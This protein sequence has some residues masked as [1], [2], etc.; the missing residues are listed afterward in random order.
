MLVTETEPTTNAA[1]VLVGFGAF[2]QLLDEAELRNIAVRPTHRC[3]GVGR[4]LLT[5]AIHLLREA[6][7]GRLFL[8]VRPSNAPARALY[9]SMGFQVVGMRPAYYADPPEDALI[10]ALEISPARA[11]L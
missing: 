4:S 10:M 3:R 2:Q 8:E 6:G 1:P 9:A 11:D 5:E 7:I